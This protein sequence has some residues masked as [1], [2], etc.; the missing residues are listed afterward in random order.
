MRFISTILLLGLIGCETKTTTDTQLS[1]DSTV[2]PISEAEPIVESNNQFALELYANLKDKKEGE[3]IFFS[4][5]SISTAMAMVYEGAHNKTAEEIQSVFHFPEDPSIRRSSFSVV[6]SYLNRRGAPYELSAANA[7]WVEKS[8]SLQNSFKTIVTEFYKGA[9]FNVDFKG[10]AE[11]E[12]KKINQWVENKT[13]DKIKNL[14]PANSLTPSTRLVLTNAVYF[15]GK[16]EEPFK[17]NQTYLED[18]WLNEN[19]RETVHMMKKTGDYFIYAQTE[20]LQILEIPY[21]GKDLSMLILLPGGKTSKDLQSLEESLTVENINLWKRNLDYKQVDVFI[22][23]FTFERDYKLKGNLK[24]MGMPLAFDML[25]Q[26]Q[27]AGFLRISEK[28]PPLYVDQVFHKAFVN[29]DEEGTIATAATGIAMN[30]T[31][32]ISPDIPPIFR[33]DHPFIFLIQERTTGYT[34]FMGKV[35]NPVQ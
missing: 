20:E 1:G 6:Q 9:V 25:G 35:A 5:Y 24:E 31:S 16:W 29:V 23:K 10:A 26:E 11:E 32:F 8:F 14:F 7:L 3:N 12:R 15:K 2:I 22:P 18:F 17:K 30:P 34:L 4:P 13:M 33:A 19:Q 28:K 27:D 21:K